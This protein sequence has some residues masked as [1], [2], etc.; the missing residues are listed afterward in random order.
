VTNITFND[1]SKHEDIAKM[2]VFA[3]HT[4]L[5]DKL[6]FSLLQAIR[7]YVEL[8]MYASFKLHTSGTI[9]AGRR[10]H[11]RFGELINVSCNPMN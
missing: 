7:G 5:T 2:M 3:A 8:D 6:G 11:E 1:G 4:I 10:A 9:A